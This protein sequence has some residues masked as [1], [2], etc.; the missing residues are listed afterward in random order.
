MAPYLHGGQ[1][2]GISFPL[3]FI[4]KGN[5]FKFDPDSVHD[6]NYGSCLEFKSRQHRAEFMNRQWIVTV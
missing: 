5:R 4:A 6:G 3:E 1:G 2:K